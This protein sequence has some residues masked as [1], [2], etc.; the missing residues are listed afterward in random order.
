MVIFDTNAI[1]RYL[2]QDNELM[3][4]IVEKQLS[5]NL[6]IVPVEVS[7][8]IIYVLTKVYDIDRQTVSKTLKDFFEIMNVQVV[9]KNVV[10]YALNVFS[11]TKLDYVDCLLIGY[12]KMEN[13]Q[14]FTFDKAINKYLQNN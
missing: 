9:K 13:A 2:L 12:N 14:I 10:I 5:E 8:E 6:C 11:I 3:A 7:A 1:I 4:D